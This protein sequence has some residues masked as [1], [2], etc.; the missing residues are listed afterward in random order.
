MRHK[1]KVKAMKYRVK[2]DH[3]TTCEAVPCERWVRDIAFGDFRFDIPRRLFDAIFE[4]IPEP[5]KPLTIGELREYCRNRCEDADC[6]AVLT[7]ALQT[8]PRS[9]LFDGDCHE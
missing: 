4:P 3:N 1:R 8:I 6:E 7:T 2:C 9:V 5:P